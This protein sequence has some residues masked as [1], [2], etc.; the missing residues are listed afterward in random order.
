MSD[1]NRVRAPQNR[2]PTL[3]RQTIWH[4][5]ALGDRTKFQADLDE[6]L[7]RITGGGVSNARPRNHVNLKNEGRVPGGP[8]FG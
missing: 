6:D 1:R 3:H 7:G 5:L 2:D 4:D 8:L